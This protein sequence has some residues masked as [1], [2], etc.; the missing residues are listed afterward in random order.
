MQC[1]STLL[2]CSQSAARTPLAA[3]LII[4]AYSLYA[5][6]APVTEWGWTYIDRGVLLVCWLI[7]H[8]W[9]SR[10]NGASYLYTC[11]TTEH[12]CDGNKRLNR[13][14]LY[15]T[16]GIVF[17]AMAD[18]CDSGPLRWRPGIDKSTNAAFIDYACL[19]S[20]HHYLSFDMLRA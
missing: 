7:G 13:I 20:I 12:Y 8:E 15:I 19:W 11:Y 14:Q 10:V 5:R 18:I 2:L 16:L 1:I 6:N 4:R 17:F 9:K 3:P